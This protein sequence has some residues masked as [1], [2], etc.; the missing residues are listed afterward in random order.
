MP[1]KTCPICKKEI[2]VPSARSSIRDHMMAEHPEIQL[3]ND[4]TCGAESLPPVF[5]AFRCLK[6]DKTFGYLKD[7]YQHYTDAHGNPPV[8]VSGAGSG[9]SP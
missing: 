2:S 4:R 6:C 7:Y 1:T 5:V 9:G 8:A 3:K